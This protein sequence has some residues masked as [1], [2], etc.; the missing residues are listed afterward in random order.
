MRP[1]RSALLWMAENER[2]AKAIPNRRFA[3]RAVRRFMPGERLD[4]AFAAAERLRDERVRVLF[5]NLGEN[6][7]SL[8]QA[9][10]VAAHYRQVLERDAQRAH[11]VGPVEISIKPSQLGLDQD[12]DACLVICHELARHCAQTGTSRL[13]CFI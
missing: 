4:D 11:V 3:Q 1:I 12:P 2:L 8:E 10:D 9:E 5:T 13:P 6:V 7:S